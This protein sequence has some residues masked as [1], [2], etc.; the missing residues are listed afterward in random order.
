MLPIQ[1]E[2]Q[3]ADR[4]AHRAK[5]PK[6]Q[7]TTATGSAEADNG[8]AANFACK[9]RL[10]GARQLI[11][12]DLLGPGLQRLE[13]RSLASRGQALPRISRG[14]ATKSMPIRWT[15]R[16]IIGNTAVD[17]L[18]PWASECV[19]LIRCGRWCPPPVPSGAAGE[20]RHLRISREREPPRHRA[21]TG[22]CI[23]TQHVRSP[24]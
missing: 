9:N 6:N 17:R 12:G 11:Q 5:E 10:C 8:T 22:T 16:R 2:A 14:E 20:G 13:S 18:W 19:G 4:Q 3:T 23:R 21:R 24:R 15:L 7:P 1:Y